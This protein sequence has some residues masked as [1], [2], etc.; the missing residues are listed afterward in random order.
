MK[1]ISK[2]MN[3]EREKRFSFKKNLSIIKFYI[4]SS[5]LSC[6]FSLKNYKY[7]L[8]ILKN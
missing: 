8:K 7:Y 3:I 5:P 1:I 2:N 6:S 4:Q